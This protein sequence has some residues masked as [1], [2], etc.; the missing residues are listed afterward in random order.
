MHVVGHDHEIVQFKPMLGDEGT[1]YIDEQSGIAFRLQ[2]S[3]A[4]AR[5]CRREKDARRA[6]NAGCGS[7]AGWMRHGRG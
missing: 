2:Q 3:L 1:Q 6:Q 7:I 5:L 4:H